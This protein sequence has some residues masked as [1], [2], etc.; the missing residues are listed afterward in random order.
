MKGKEKNKQKSGRKHGTFPQLPS[1]FHMQAVTLERIPKNRSRGLPRV[2]LRRRENQ[3]NRVHLRLLY[4]VG[5]N[6]GQLGLNP[7]GSS[8]KLYIMH[9]RIIYSKERREEYLSSSSYASLIKGCPWLLI[10]LYFLVH[11][12][13][14]MAKSSWRY[15]SNGGK[16][17]EQKARDPQCS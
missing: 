11:P 2:T 12:C 15:P 3:F 6:G 9:L 1:W 13:V 14:T 17:L 16:A 4:K 8:E 10:C 5:Q 7:L